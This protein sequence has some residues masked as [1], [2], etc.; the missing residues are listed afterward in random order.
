M[1]KSLSHIKIFLASSMALEERKEFP[2]LVLQ[3]QK[4]LDGM[5]LEPVLC[6]FD[7]PS[8]DF[9]GRRFQDHFN[10]LL[11]GCQIALVIFY[12]KA[13]EFTIEELQRARQSCRKTFVYFKT[14]FRPTNRAENSA[15]DKVFELKESFTPGAD[16]IYGE[17]TTIA[18][19]RDLFKT[20]LQKY[21]K[22]EKASIS[23]TVS[24]L[25][26]RLFSHPL[27]DRR[28]FTGRIQELDDLAMYFREP[29]NYLGLIGAGGIGKTSLATQYLLR[30]EGRHNHVV[31]VYCAEGARQALLSDAVLRQ[32][33]ISQEEQQLPDDQRLLLLTDRLAALPGHP[34]LVLD[35][36]DG[37]GE[38][39]HPDRQTALLLRQRLPNW[40]IL[41]TLRLTKNG[42][43]SADL[44]TLPVG[45]LKEDDARKLFFDA[46]PAAQEV[47]EDLLL[48]LIQTTGGHALLVELLA[49]NYQKVLD[50]DLPGYDFAAYCHDLEQNGV[51]DLTKKRSVEVAWRETEGRIDQILDQLYD[52]AHIDADEPAKNLLALLALLPPQPIRV[53]H[54]RRIFGVD[55]DEDSTVQEFTETLDRLCRRGWLLFVERSN[56]EPPAYGLLPILAELT[57][58][59][60]VPKTEGIEGLVDRLTTL[61]RT[62]KLGIAK[63]FL[64]YAQSV[65]NAVENLDTANVA[66]LAIWSGDRLKE[67]GEMPAAKNMYEAS[68]KIHEKLVAATPGT[69]NLQRQLAV[70]ISRLGGIALALGNSN[71]ARE[72]FEKY[73][74]IIHTLATANPD[75]QRLQRDLAISYSKLGDVAIHNGQTNEAQ[76]HF[77][78]ASAILAGL[79]HANPDA[80]YLQQELAIS[81]GRLG[82]MALNLG[83]LEEATKYLTTVHGINQAFFQANPNSEDLQ[84]SLAKSFAQLAHLAFNRRKSA[85]AQ[86]YYENAN[87]LFQTLA[88][89][90]PDAEGL[91]Q[92]L[93][94]TFSSLGDMALQYGKL[95]E[96]QLLY[97]KGKVI[98]EK[99]A[100]A[101]PDSEGLQRELAVSFSKLGNV[102]IKLGKLDI[103]QR[104]L[105][106]SHAAC[107]KLVF[108]NPAFERFKHDLARSFS[109]L[110]DLAEGLGRLEEAQNY[111]EQYHKIYQE[112]ATANPL[113]EDLQNYLAKSFDKLGS[114]ELSHN[115]L[116]RAA[117]FFENANEILTKLATSNPISAEILLNRAVSFGKL[118]DVAIKLKKLDKARQFLT[119]ANQQIVKL[120]A[121]DPESEELQINLAIS[122]SKL[123]DLALN[124]GKAKEAKKHYQKYHQICLRLATANPVSERFQRNLAV[125]WVALGDSEMNHKAAQPFWQKGLKLLEQRLAIN[126]TSADLQRLVR[127]TRDR[128]NL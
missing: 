27:W 103:A 11:D 53:A 83:N 57:R 126:P 121:E 46:C 117:H 104:Y 35:N 80:D 40:S 6:E 47:P 36:A 15:L 54:L 77:Q 89:S 109:R 106:Q 86:E 52:F 93:A 48:G 102:A 4:L 22:D 90:N 45:K 2:A 78:N 42:L 60:I 33:F 61:L 120:L 92:E 73:H 71:E 99:I 28:F 119:K 55:P 3:I 95:E 118:G 9:G 34:L 72:H 70:V 29:G 1:H 110:G 105:E 100:K 12:D 97:E 75:L 67:M 10:Q 50:D 41:A 59:K 32:H 44:P 7:S 84:R 30:N 79:V 21:L 108:A 101:N 65:V 66:N 38:K 14:G 26:R 88:D 107:Q 23:P 115:K 111:F 74:K 69:E 8:G 112:L 116:K 62:E 18:D 16:L 87:T 25:P 56:T 63:T 127:N 5:F 91:Q 31:W 43:Q 68:L 82:D 123:G 81:F 64:G 13:G 113:R 76:K 85:E 39:D 37:I 114:V 122:F 128:L 98:F 49:K 124:T 125:S 17:F 94:A 24:A 58:R 96:A 51:L 20:D 19:F